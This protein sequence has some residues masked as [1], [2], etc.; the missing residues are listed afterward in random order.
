[1]DRNLIATSRSFND[2]R[3]LARNR[4]RAVSGRFVQLLRRFLRRFQVAADRSVEV[5]VGELQVVG[6]RNRLAVA[7]LLA[8]H[9]NG[10][11]L[12]QFCL[13][14]AAKILEHLRPR[15]QARLADDPM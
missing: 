3:V 2:L 7:D 6:R 15:L 14:G 13:A 9:V 4:F 8:H 5:L 10:E 11:R 12:S 1:M